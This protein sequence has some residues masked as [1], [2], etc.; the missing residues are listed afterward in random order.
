[1]EQ[2]AFSS[3]IRKALARNN[4]TSPAER[5]RVYAAARSALRRRVSA[6]H[7]SMSVLEAAIE[8]VEAPFRETRAP[9]SPKPRAPF[10][11]RLLPF[12]LGVVLGAATIALLP[13]LF[14]PADAQ[15]DEALQKLERQYRNSLPQ[16]QP[17]IEFLR[18]VT[19]SVMA[20]Q[21]SDRAMLEEKAAKKFVQLKVLDEKLASDMPR[22]LP[23][24]SVVTVR[25]NRTDFKVLFNWP[26]CGAVKIT[27]P[28]LV[29][30]ARA[31][32]G[33]VLGCTHFGFW[34]PGAAGW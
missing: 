1:M 23:R 22:S 30:P 20:L 28:G 24:D 4:A 7:A 33:D 10:L 26:L 31:K 2:E 5:E 25:A 34:T 21:K 14:S 13:P 32:S 19:D 15:D 9:E 6:D 12:G 16:V 17:A 27:Q 18:K 3:T 29:D 11:S 8:S